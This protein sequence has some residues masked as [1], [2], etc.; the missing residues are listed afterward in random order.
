MGG[1]PGDPGS[2]N[3]CA[4]VGGDPVNRVDPGGADYFDPTMQQDGAFSVCIQ[5]GT[6][7]QGLNDPM[8]LIDLSEDPNGG[9]YAD[10]AGCGAVLAAYL[11]EGQTCNTNYAS[12]LMSNGGGPAQQT[13]CGPGTTDTPEPECSI[14]LWSRPA[15]WNSSL[16][17]GKHTYIDVTWTNYSGLES[18]G[19]GDSGQLVLQGGSS[20]MN[21]FGGYLTGEADLPGTG[22]GANH[23]N[24]S[25]P[26][27]PHNTEIGGSYTLPDACSDI[28]TML[29]DMDAYDASGTKVRYNLL[30]VPGTYNSNSF[31][32]TLLQN[33]ALS[34]YFGNPTLFGWGF[35]VPGL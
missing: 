2:W 9:C 25:L 21:A 32:Y 5:E 14:Q 10:P 35:S 23:N 13:D 8:L 33:V 22:M 19:Y 1:H 6:C 27:A 24:T 7:D 20:T 30:A 34:S 17:P 4:Y 12:E 15:Y 16:N 3:K 26:G 31:T 11:A 18:L 28:L 29:L